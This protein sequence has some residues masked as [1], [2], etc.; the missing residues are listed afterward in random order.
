[1]R[2]GVRGCRDG[3]KRGW[4]DTWIYT[5]SLRFACTH[6]NVFGIL[7]LWFSLIFVQQLS[8]LCKSEMRPD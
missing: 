8:P 3:G 7:T 1:M 4:M 2:N 5:P 6:L